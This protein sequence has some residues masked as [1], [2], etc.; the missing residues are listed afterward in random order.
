MLAG[1]RRY[2][3]LFDLDGVTID[4][5]AAIAAALR[6]L[7]LAWSP[8]AL[9][10]TVLGR[11]AAMPPVQALGLLGVSEPRAV[12]DGHFDAALSG[13]TGEGVIVFDGVVAAMSALAAHGAGI[14]IVTAQAR[15]RI[16]FWV[17]PAV[18]ELAEVVVAYEDAAP[19]PAPDGVLAACAHLGV[20]PERAFFLGDSATDIEAG[21]AA[22]VFTI[23]AGW[24]FAGAAVLREA[25][26]DLVLAGPDEVGPELLKYLGTD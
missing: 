15:S 21:R 25:G 16:G 11:C 7:A 19:K 10:E 2:A 6:S 20:T 3:A 5:R 4:G 14:G 23:G 1:E 22:G 26:A 13:A 24:G 17:P 12:Y 18:A 8:T 9:D